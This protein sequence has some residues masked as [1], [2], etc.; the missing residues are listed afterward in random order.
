MKEKDTLGSVMEKL[1]PEVAPPSSANWWIFV[2]LAVGILGGG[3]AGGAAGFLISKSA[4][5]GVQANPTPSPITEVVKIVTDESQDQNFARVAASVVGIYKNPG[6]ADTVSASLFR[7]EG[8]PLTSDGWIISPQGVV[9]SDGVVWNRRWYPAE[10]L[11]PDPFTGVVFLKVRASGFPLNP[12]ASRDR[13]KEGERLV[14]YGKEGS[15]FDT[16]VL[17][18][19]FIEA[20]DTAL[21]SEIL[22]AFARV[23]ESSPGMPLFDSR[24]ELAG[25]ALGDGKMLPAE[26]IESALKTILK[27]GKVRRPY[28]GVSSLDRSS[29]IFSQA[30][31]LGALV[32]AAKD[33]LA[34]ERGSPASVSGLK[35]GDVITAVENLELNQNQTLAEVLVRFSPG[36]KVAVKYLRGGKE[37]TVSVTLGEKN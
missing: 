16:R 18:P 1:R 34:V 25:M 14:G 19:R 9:L 15:V 11:I 21:R 37:E 13:L 26:Y 27:E 5:G 31:L 23:T 28:F 32:A 30:P 17:L 29:Q 6:K 3:M 24:G 8:I 35:E 36:T 10:K 12:F 22:T 4:T 2:S 33:A 20:P 7:S